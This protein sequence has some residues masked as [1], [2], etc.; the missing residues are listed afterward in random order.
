MTK[1]NTV[2]VLVVLVFTTSCT[3][4]DIGSLP[5]DA[6]EKVTS[7]NIVIVD[8]KSIEENLLNNDNMLTD[9]G[10]SEVISLNYHNDKYYWIEESS[11][12]H[13]V[14]KTIEWFDFYYNLKIISFLYENDII[15]VDFDSSA[16]DR[17]FEESLYL[18]DALI[19]TLSSYP[20]VE[21]IILLVDGEAGFFGNQAIYP[22]IKYKDCHDE[23]DTAN[24]RF[25]FTDGID[26]LFP[27]NRVDR[28][29]YKTE[30][31]SRVNLVVSV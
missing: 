29:D 14:K 20:N 22:A 11:S 13:L 12:E 16:K 17:L 27:P 21:K 9:D 26:P 25:F 5:S 28:L 7:E 10:V 31:I 30:Q 8:S 4:F 1:R 23:W 15:K 19:K 3:K 24:V 18:T 6:T 2:I